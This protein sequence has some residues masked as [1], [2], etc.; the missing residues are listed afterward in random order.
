MDTSPKDYWVGHG[1]LWEVVVSTVQYVAI[2]L[3]KHWMP[4]EHTGCL[5]IV[6]AHL[7]INVIMYI[8][9]TPTHTTLLILD[10]CFAMIMQ[11]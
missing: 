5:A 2:P 8:Y 9:T 3:D 4:K 7:Y 6:S 11:S 10:Y 1:S